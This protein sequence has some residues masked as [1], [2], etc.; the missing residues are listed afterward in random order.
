MHYVLMIHAAEARFETLSK[1]AGETI[2]QAYGTYTRELHATGK[3]GDCAAL[4][5]IANATSVRVR[6]G[7]RTVQDGPFAETREQLGGYYTIDAENEEEAFAWAAKIPDA[8]AGTI[9]VRPVFVM[10]GPTAGAKGP[11]PLPEGH[12]EY[13]LLIYEPEAR[14]ATMSDQEKGAAM[15]GYKAFQQSLGPTGQ[16]RAGDRLASVRTAKSVSV[17]SNERV[18]RDGPFAETR[19]QLGGYYRISA[20][21]LD[22]AIALAARLPAAESGTIEVRPLRDTSAYVQPR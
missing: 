14:W 1:E 5:P 2:M 3:A 18:V 12:R 21:N 13:L 16:L 8:A 10:G 22:E 6:D 17:K 15:G 19:E 20:R 4:T 9:E 11:G 7:Q